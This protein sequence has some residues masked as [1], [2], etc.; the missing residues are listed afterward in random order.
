MF[1][2]DVEALERIERA[3][4]RDLAA[5]APPG[6]AARVGLAS[7]EF[8]EALMLTASAIPTFQFNWLSGAGLAGADPDAI[9][10]GVAR[11]RAAGQSRYFVQI[12]PTPQLAHCE[13]QARAAELAPHPVAWV[14]F[15]RETRAP[16]RVETT[17]AIHEVSAAQ[18]ALFAATVVAGF[19]LPS[20]MTDWLSQ[21]V[22]RPGWSCYLAFAGEEPAGGGAL[23]VDEDAAWLG[24]GATRPDFRRRGGQSALIA[25][26]L[27][28]AARLGAR[29]AVTE[30]RA[31]R[32][33]EPA[34]SHR[35]ILAAG[36]RAAY[37]RPNWAPPG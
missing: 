20:I 5:A 29:F 31:P 2:N 15:E 17:L 36:F 34:P 26:R 11:F 7:H 21:I 8:G 4:W 13:A 10:S 19:G 16:P 25:R 18:R 23:F 1:D 32:F 24:V 33:G 9:P 27:A 37:A 14:K 30:T 12:P 6:F 28:E 22:G 35:N 3:A